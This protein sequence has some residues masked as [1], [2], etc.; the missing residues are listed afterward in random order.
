MS[1]EKCPFK[2]ESRYTPEQLRKLIHKN[3]KTNYMGCRQMWPDWKPGLCHK[4]KV[5]CA[6]FK[7]N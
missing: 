7:N 5:V 3:Y 2:E 4:G 6:G 1:C